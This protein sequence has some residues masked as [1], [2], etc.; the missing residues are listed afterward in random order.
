MWLNEILSV[1]C[2]VPNAGNHWIPQL[3]TNT[4]R[5]SIAKRAMV[6]A[7]G[8]KGLDM[9]LAL[10]LFKW[11]KLDTWPRWP[12]QF[13]DLTNFIET[14]KPRIHNSIFNYSW[15]ICIFIGSKSNHLKYK[16]LN[17]VAWLSIHKSTCLPGYIDVGDGCW[18][19]NKWWWQFLDVVGIQ[20][21]HQYLTIVTK[22]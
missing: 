19:Q 6:N 5:K 10:E 7:L 18:R 15:M 20:N 22:S 17:T 16:P 1:A 13:A 8:Q 4:K 12:R 21:C 2:A 3:W 9:V 11:L 14:V